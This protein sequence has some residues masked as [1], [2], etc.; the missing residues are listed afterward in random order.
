MYIKYKFTDKQLYTLMYTD[1]HFLIYSQKTNSVQ[2]INAFLTLT[3]LDIK[4]VECV[5]YLNKASANLRAAVTTRPKF[6][7]SGRGLFEDSESFVETEY[8]FFLLFFFCS[9]RLDSPLL[10]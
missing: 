9:V 7:Y 8:P 4:G 2:H 10:P 1:F 5:A 6:S 3:C